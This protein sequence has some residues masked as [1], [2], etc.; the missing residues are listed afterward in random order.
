MGMLVFQL[1][2]PNVQRQEIRLYGCIFL[3]CIRAMFMVSKKNVYFVFPVVA[4]PF[5]VSKGRAEDTLSSLSTELTECAFF[6][7]LP[8]GLCVFRF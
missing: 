1:P 5:F 4:P 6:E 8:F 3:S 2:F 7:E